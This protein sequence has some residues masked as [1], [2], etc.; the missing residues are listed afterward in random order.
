MAINHNKKRNSGM[1]REFFSKYLAECLVS[2][3][4]KKAVEARTIWKKHVCEGTELYKEMR[5][6]RIMLETKFGNKHVANKFMSKI[7][8]NVKSIDIE[9][10]SREKTA[11]IREINSKLGF[12]F[13]DY[14]LNNYT[15]LA[16]IH[17]LLNE[18]MTDS[19]SASAEFFELEDKVLNFLCEKKEIAGSN[20]DLF[21]SKN[22]DGLV[23]KIMQEKLNKKYS[24]ILTEGQ[25]KILQQYIF[26]TNK[27]ELQETLQALRDE[28]VS[29]I[30]REISSKKNLQEKAN[31]EKIKNLLEEEYS[32]ISDV[33]DSNV[34]FYMTVSKL[35]DDLKDEK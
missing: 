22:V 26:G 7:S 33:D 4:K 3:N 21:E 2:N 34:V 18:W 27:K 31:L 10:L 20:V 15:D 6:S 16:S 24:K 23:V 12:S 8:E 19:K 28:T 29:L 9:K 1:L 5:I 11:L 35:N 30:T 32:N 17:V 13:F 25:K 14:N